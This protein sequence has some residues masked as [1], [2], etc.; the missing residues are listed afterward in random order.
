MYTEDTNLEALPLPTSSFKESL[1][2]YESYSPTTQRIYKPSIEDSAEVQF[3]SYLRSY[4][5]RELTYQS[6]V[7]NDFAGILKVFSP[8]LGTHV[9]GFPRY[10]FH[11]VMCWKT[12][13][14]FPS[15]R[16]TEFPSWSWAGWKG[17]KDVDWEGYSGGHSRIWWWSMN[18]QGRF[19]LIDT[20]RKDPVDSEFTNE[21]FG[22]V[23]FS[24]PPNPADIF[25]HDNRDSEQPPN[26][27][28]WHL[29]FF[30]TSAVTVSISDEPIQAR[31]CYSEYSIYDPGHFTSIFTIVLDEMWR[32]QRKAHNHFEIIFISQTWAHRRFKFNEFVET[33]LVEW[34]NGMAY[35]VQQLRFRL[36]Q[37]ESFKP[38]FKLIT[39]A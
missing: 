9:C 31:G 15:C 3:R 25:W 33:L 27:P 7:I 17:S 13:G 2:D 21:F 30:W 26:P 38:Q 20:R 35:R 32:R 24:P 18:D 1:L 34:E 28:R 22:V 8:Q 29:L 16:R 37:W 11:T 6:D 19:V 36:P 5:R 39:L 10:L 23:T 12:D 14:H 4:M